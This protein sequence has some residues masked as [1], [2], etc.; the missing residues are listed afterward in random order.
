M[1]T[2]AVRCGALFRR[3]A[4]EGGQQSNWW[5]HSILLPF[6][7][8]C[9]RRVHAHTPFCV[10]PQ[11]SFACPLIPIRAYSPVCLSPLP[12]F[13]CCCCR[14]REH[15]LCLSCTFVPG[16]GCP[17]VV[18]FAM[19]CT[20]LLPPYHPSTYLRDHPYH[21]LTYV[22][23]PASRPSP[24]PH[25]HPRQGERAAFG[26]PVTF[27]AHPFC[28]CACLRRRLAR[29]WMT[30]RPTPHRYDHVLGPPRSSAESREPE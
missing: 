16:C 29:W 8:S 11:F 14:R 26:P 12:S 18:L 21:D 3:T 4:D 2:R 22:P 5:C 20:P 24:H 15:P 1:G 27:L 6:H 9:P 30:P 23:P 13:C 17:S 10:E 7:A 25:T 19:F 28:R